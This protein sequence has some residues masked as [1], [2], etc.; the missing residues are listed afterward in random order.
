MTRHP[1]LI[2]VV[3]WC[4]ALIAMACGPGLIDDSLPMDTDTSLEQTTDVIVRLDTPW[5]IDTDTGVPSCPEKISKT[6]PE[7][8]GTFEPPSSPLV[9]AE[10][11]NYPAQFT[12]AARDLI[13][14]M[15]D[16]DDE[17]APFIIQ[18]AFD[19]L[20][21]QV[22]DYRSLAHVMTLPSPGIEDAEWIGVFHSPQQIFGT[23][24]RDMAVFRKETSYRIIDIPINR[25]VFTLS[26]T[27]WPALE[28]SASLT[29]ATYLASKSALRDVSLDSLCLHG[30]AL[31]CFNGTDWITEI[32]A[33]QLRSPIVAMA[34]SH[35]NDDIFVHALCENGDIFT[36][37]NNQWS[38]G[39]IQ[40]DSSLTAASVNEER[41]ILFAAGDGFIG[42]GDARFPLLRCDVDLDILDFHFY[43]E[44]A[45]F[46]LLTQSGDFY[47]G[48]FNFYT[49]PSLC[50]PLTH[51]DDAID[52]FPV[53]LNLYALTEDTLYGTQ[54]LAIMVE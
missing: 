18:V 7:D 23:D 10:W 6:C 48:Q 33:E 46:V 14:G 38:A 17:S 45:E 13:A 36:R 28:T 3:L 21:G 15:F 42:R 19:K 49:A 29:G 34:I 35:P 47:S 2:C 30:D 4:S 11:L 25:D 44:N 43:Q 22:S 37:H 31:I 53:G 24:I 9:S 40:I 20:W 39:T 32:D 27:S 50:G 26:D 52:I 54:D 8:V 1:V 16:I 12:H 5:S 41:Q 51:I